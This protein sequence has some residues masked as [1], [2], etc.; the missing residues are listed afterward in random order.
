M[1]EIKQYYINLRHIVPVLSGAKY[2]TASGKLRFYAG[3]LHLSSL[4]RASD[5]GG[6][7]RAEDQLIP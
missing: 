7:V 5:T 4:C 6:P 1:H 3:Q 2:K